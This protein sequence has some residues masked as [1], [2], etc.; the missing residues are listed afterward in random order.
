MILNC[1]FQF[2]M[3]RIPLT[4]YLITPQRLINNVTKMCLHNIFNVLPALKFI[5][6]KR[7]KIDFKLKKSKNILVIF[8]SIECYVGSELSTF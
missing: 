5:K 2:Y 1:L 6:K 4:K 8:K 3:I 7:D